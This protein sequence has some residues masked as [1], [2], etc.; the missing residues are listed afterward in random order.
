[1]T[2]VYEVYQGISAYRAM[3]VHAQ[4]PECPRPME[5]PGLS[6]LRQ[7]ILKRYLNR[8]ICLQLSTISLKQVIRTCIRRSAYLWSSSNFLSGLG[9]CRKIRLPSSKT[10][11]FVVRQCLNPRLAFLTAAQLQWVP[12]L[13]QALSDW[14]EFHGE[15]TSELPNAYEAKL[16]NPCRLDRELLS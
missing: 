13:R 5:G 11:S 1:M 9:Y 8:F 4:V 10:W 12:V 15:E 16:P 2:I 7:C 3:N 14:A 6:I